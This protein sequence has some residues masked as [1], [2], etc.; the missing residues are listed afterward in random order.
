MRPKKPGAIVTRMPAASPQ[1]DAPINAHHAKTATA[2]TLA[3]IAGSQNA[4]FAG[5]T[6]QKPLTRRKKAAIG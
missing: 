2:A 4:A 3:I 1:R 6:P 5:A